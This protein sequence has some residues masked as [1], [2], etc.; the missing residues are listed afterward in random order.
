MRQQL[1]TL[2]GQRLT[3]TAT[4]DL[5]SV[6]NG[7]RGPVATLMLKDVCLADDGRLV[8][9]HLWWDKGAWAKELHVGDRISFEA[10]VSSYE[11]GYKGRDFERQAESPL[12][13]DYRLERP[14]KVKVQN[15]RQDCGRR[16]ND[17]QR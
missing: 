14:T 17:G 2:L 4:V 9:E 7:Y 13:T 10:R 6:K 16:N 12:S 8:T 3:F 5:F 15:E 1:K 11:K